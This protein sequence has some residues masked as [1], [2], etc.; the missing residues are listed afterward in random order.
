MIR[1][2]SMHY[3]LSCLVPNWWKNFMGTLY[4]RSF[5]WLRLTSRLFFS[6]HI[7]LNIEFTIM[8]DALKNLNVCKQLID[9][10]LDQLVINCFGKRANFMMKAF[11]PTWEKWKQLRIFFLDNNEPKL[12]KRGQEFL[13]W[14]IWRQY[15]AW[16]IELSVTNCNN[17]S[18]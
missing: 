4:L 8:K 17:L 6:K 13:Y 10:L 7:S 16:R 5:L 3:T 11:N 2:V 15:F 12:M 18:P 1:K 14:K 9:Q